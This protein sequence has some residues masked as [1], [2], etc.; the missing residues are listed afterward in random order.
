MNATPSI[1]QSAP[2]Y[3]LRFCPLSG[4]G[5]VRAFPC[6]AEGHVDIDALSARTRLDYFYARTVIGREFAR[7]AVQASTL[8]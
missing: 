5:P 3:E 1:S 2:G 6:D 8:H 4:H 7:P